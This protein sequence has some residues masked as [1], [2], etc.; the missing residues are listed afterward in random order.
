MKIVDEVLTE[1]N[2]AVLVKIDEDE[3]WLPKSQIEL[4]ENSNGVSVVQL[5]EWLAIDKGLV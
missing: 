4:D 5:P 1:T 2:K 3:L